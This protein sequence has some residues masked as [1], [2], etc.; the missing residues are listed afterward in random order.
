MK[1]Q[2]NKNRRLLLGCIADDITGAS[3]I[4]LMLSNNG[5][6]ATVFLG[7]PDP[8]IE[9]STEAVVIA[10][11]IRTVPASEAVRQ[12]VK[13]AKWLLA[14]NSD[15]LL[16][17]YCSTF[18]S[19][20]A[21]NIGPVT[22]ALLRLLGTDLTVILPAF[23]ANGRTVRNGRLYVNDLPLN[24]SSMR[25][26]PLT[27][28]TESYLPAL[29]DAQTSPGLTASI[30]SPVVDAG[31]IA[32]RKA[33]DSAHDCGKRFIS[34]DTTTNEHLR[35][36]A[37]AIAGMKLITGSAGIAG[38][39]P[40][41]LREAG[42][43]DTRCSR[44]T[45]PLADGNAAI[46][47]G[48]CSEAT[49]RQVEMFA[50]SAVAIPIDVLKLAS[51]AIDKKSIAARAVDAV[52]NGNILVYSSIEPETLRSVQKSLGVE[53]S[54]DLVEETLAYVAQKLAQSDVRIFVVAGGET[55]G[56]VATALGISELRVGEEIDPGVPWLVTPTT[57]PTC[58]AFKS[59]NFGRPDFF[60]YALDMLQ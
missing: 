32:I 37:P 22:D 57:P 56:A 17:K 58:L 29:M 30:A 19:T 10:L 47:A 41:T 45:M 1:K 52:A 14:N 5:L 18:D 9:L 42:K 34:I 2:T 48:S 15:Q 3:D 60:R 13:A 55:S 27:P 33:I 53:Q 8:E 51:G 40:E 7:V 6:P 39:I 25:D 44:T 21:G 31:P 20:S 46:L 54:A 59:G 26:H 49:R 24:E 4:G 11:K 36:I 12:A 38:A 28:M 23:P 43:L 50:D 35:A 16:Y